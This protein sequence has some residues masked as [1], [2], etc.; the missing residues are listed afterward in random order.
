MDT[1][2]IIRL[3]DEQRYQEALN[4][5]AE[6]FHSLAEANK[7][8]DIRKFMDLPEEGIKDLLTIMDTAMM[9][10]W[11]RILTRYSHR[12]LKSQNT[13][14]WHCEEL[15]DEHKVVKAEDLLKELEKE[16]LS[17]KT[18]E[19]LYF[20]IAVL[21]LHMQRFNEARKYL[22]KCEKV[23]S[24]S[25]NTRWA[26]Y[27]L[28]KGEWEEAVQLL[29]KGKKDKKDGA[30]AYALLVQH[31]SLQGDLEGAEA[32][33]NE[34]LKEH[35]FY[36]K[37]LLEKIRIQYRRKQW[38]QMRESIA[39]LRSMSPYH[40]FRDM[41]EFYEAESFY[42]EEK[43]TELEQYLAAH[44]GLRKN[45]RFQKFSGSKTKPA[46]MLIYRQVVQKP[47]Y[48]VPASA[49]M[50]FSMFSSDITQDLV[51]EAI[52]EVAGSKISKAMDF[53]HVQGFYSVLFHGNE[54]R[55]K[56]LMDLE[57]GVLITIDYPTSS[58]VQV[59]VGYD[60][61]LEIF[62]VH[63]PNFREPYV[64][65]YDELEKEFG[66]NG[67]LSV[68]VV[69]L[70]Q[71]D[72]LNFLNEQEHEIAK[73][74]LLLTEDCD[75]PLGPQDIDYLNRHKENPI[76]AVYGVKY[77]ADM[78]EEELLE[79]MIK[80][81]EQY[82][83][84]SVY[85]NLIIGMAYSRVK[86]DE[87]AKE[88]LNK[89]SSSTQSS[90]FWYLKGKLSFDKG[91]YVKAA[92]EFKKA[93]EIEPD[94]YTLWSYWAISVSNTGDTREGLKLSEIA[95]DINSEDFFPVCNHGMILFDSGRHE[96]ARIFFTKALHIKKSSPHIWYERA[97]CDLQL[98]RF[99]QAE[100]GFAAVIGLDS[101]LALP[102]KELANIY[103]F[104]HEDQ[105]AAGE[106]L[107]KG[108]EAAEDSFIL[109]RELGELY[110]RSK[111]YEKARFYY[112]EAADKE[113]EDPEA[114]ISLAALYKEEGNL[115]EF[116]KTM[117]GLQDR[118]GENSE[119]LINGGKMIWEAAQETEEGKKYLEQGLSLVEKGLRM[120][121][122]NLE[123]ALELYTGLI[124]DSPLYRRGI[125]FLEGEKLVKG[126]QFLYTCYAGYLYEHNGYYVKARNYYER[127]LQQ[128][129]D[130]LPL[131]R[132]GDV[133]FKMEDYEKA[134]FYFKKV[135]EIDPAHEQA[136]LDLASIARREENQ[137][138][139]LYFLLEAFKVNPYSINVEAAAN[140]MNRTK[141]EQ[142][143]NDFR[144]L[145]E[146]KYEKSFIYDSIAVINGQLGNLGEEEAYLAKAL[147]LSPELP[148]LQH[149]HAKLLLKKGE[150]K[151]ARKIL[152]QLIGKQ[153]DNREYCDTLIEC[154]GK[155][156]ANL[157]KDLGKLKLSPREKSMAFM[158]CA[159]A[160]EKVVLPM[161]EERA[162]EEVKGFFRKISSFSKFSFH[163]GVLVS[164]YE[165]AIKTDRDNVQ[166]AVWLSD[167]YMTAFLTED[168]IKTLEKAL[169]HNWDESLAYKL[170]LLYVNE[171]EE[172]N[173]K[174]QAKHLMQAQSI[175]GNLLE[176][177]EQPEYMSLLGFTFFLQEDY[178]EAEALYLEC[179]EREPDIDK[180]YY[181][182]GKVYTEMERYREAE[183]AMRKA[184][185]QTPDDPEAWNEIGIIYRMQD[186]TADALQCAERALKLEPDDPYYKY[187]RACYLSLLDRYRESAQQL[188][189]LFELDEEGVFIDMSLDDEDL[190]AL[191]ES[192]YFPL[193][194]DG[195]K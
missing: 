116:F 39:V 12:K 16:K 76:V 179:L 48:C 143:L 122:T 63:D 81:S 121:E 109:L 56:K 8:S 152:L 176:H 75:Q 186:R 141:L 136:L 140:L 13:M 36:P 60:D 27:L 187:N 89:I 64:L 72:K 5:F 144:N 142:F 184:L 125:D 31:Y 82:L 131:Y 65:G 79:C 111:D 108:I 96:E 80:V 78:M 87:Q 123:E 19:K 166:A 17:P 2:P 85:R 66:N 97:R 114:W 33:V 195:S 22:E 58:H 1:K 51:G 153:D 20:N 149:H 99:R 165:M 174:K 134:S 100:R 128:K 59:L 90:T 132:L 54:E 191:R 110:E 49:E 62:T 170:A 25:M 105:A 77:L 183:Q 139:E 112:L 118:F 52:F 6:E 4:L 95:L 47:N 94:D 101:S 193:A 42:D 154:Y 172:F 182:L 190:E 119:F 175:L 61:N 15:I 138:E 40:D 45:T 53:F 189:D 194:T 147:E 130:L 57:A 10:Q 44:P 24:D 171:R 18:A 28:H 157:E 168:A 159:A 158:H 164:L 115:K 113:P 107:R 29:E 181:Y 46:K 98:D 69:P 70:E 151:Q 50:I 162:N 124:Q 102:Y 43:W 133:H 120:T 21:L 127:A 169:A 163:L 188:E 38:P 103:E 135:L 41:V 11:S 178:T 93:V 137:R 192:G 71:K 91:E 117:N 161:L 7:L 173:E 104:V 83:S 180:G 26:Y 129:E 145:D 73:K 14:I 167:F 34:G 150:E 35:P 37:L 68:A 160:Y 126:D 3:L 148:Q 156:V 88:C 177:D 23:T 9:G 74:I 84:D 92:E 67:A 86:K 30:L 32:H 146:K 55:F 106:M 155:S 185:E